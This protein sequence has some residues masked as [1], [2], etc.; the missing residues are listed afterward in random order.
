MGLFKRARPKPAHGAVEPPAGHAIR[1]ADSV[2]DRQRGRSHHGDGFPQRNLM[3]MRSPRPPH[4]LTCGVLLALIALSLRVQ[5]LRRT[6]QVARK[7]GARRWRSFEVFPHDLVQRCV[8]RVARAAAFFP[9]RAECLEQSL[10][11]LVLLR[12]RGLPAQL[13]VGVR[14][15]PFAAHAWVELAGRP[16]NE[17]E[18]F[19][20]QLTPFPSIGG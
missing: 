20:T 8:E 16:V 10:A 6:L 7:C 5:G 9:G 13:R 19:V 14:S 12:R 18:D 2:K 17:P 11:L 4:V 3:T 1:P 15:L